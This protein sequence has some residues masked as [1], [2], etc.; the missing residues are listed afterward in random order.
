M[1]IITEINSE[2]DIKTFSVLHKNVWI[3]AYS[4]LIDNSF[5]KNISVKQKQKNISMD[6]KNNTHHFFLVFENQKP[7]GILV[8]KF[9]YSRNNEGEIVAIYLLKDYWNKGI[10]KQM[11]D[12][13]IHFF[14]QK[15][16]YCI[17]LWVLQENNR[18]IQFYT[19]Y[20]FL[21]TTEKKQLSI[22]N[23]IYT[24]KKYSFK[25]K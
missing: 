14:N 12:F 10:G 22:K 8:L 6:I 2:D 18:A 3:D 21:E 25:I 17:Y 19:K 23:R 5:L 4:K 13:S 1:I 11:M 7:I 20:G 9:N 16:I 24:E 15:N